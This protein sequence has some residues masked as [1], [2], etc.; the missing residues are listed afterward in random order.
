MIRVVVDTNVLVSALI[1]KRPSPPLDI[2]N[3]LKS[4]D[5]LLVTSPAILQELEEVINREVIV[6]LHQKTQKQI[7]EILYEIT[8][9]SYIV[10]GLVSVEVVKKDPNDNMFIAAALEGKADFVVSGD[11]PLLNIKEYQNI[12]IIS[13]KDFIRLLKKMPGT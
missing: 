11:K 4:E 6:K 7:D 2:Y 13:P 12:K 1:S 3:L 8:E 10:A 5:F 9:T